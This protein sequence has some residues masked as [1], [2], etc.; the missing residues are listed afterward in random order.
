[1]GAI[2][3]IT[4]FL[5]VSSSGHLILAERILGIGPQG[6][7]FTVMVHVGTVL[8]V[9]AVFHKRIFKIIKALFCG[10]V[11]YRKGRLRFPDQYTRWAWLLV[12][13]T[14]PAAV[15]GIVLGDMIEKEFC[16]PFGVGICLL[17][18]GGF[19]F[20]TRFVL[21]PGKE[22]SWF[23]ALA[24]GIAQIGGIFPGIS[25]SGI[26]ISAG[27]YSGLKRRESA[28]F[29]FLLGIPLILGAGAGKITAMMKMGISCSEF[30]N[31]I[32][33]AL[34]AA[35]TGY[36][37]IK[38]VLKIIIMGRFGFFAYYCWTVGLLVI[39]FMK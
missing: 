14:I 27:I 15:M 11:R 1:M 30:I 39:V 8:A 21:S 31:I 22:L 18:T 3:G 25:R 4:E 37:A 5:P 38:I 24:V 29:S 7:R 26:T 35:V 23:R 17:L 2:Q 34:T 6:L 12:L 13:A 36:I 32:A 10:R 28:E 19:L 20:G 16:R 33:G 9:I